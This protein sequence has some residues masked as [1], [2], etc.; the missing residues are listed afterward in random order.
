MQKT[1]N[2]DFNT[3]VDK[4][5][6]EVREG[7]A[8]KKMSL[9]DISRKMTAAYDEMRETLGKEVEAA[10]QEGLDTEAANCP[11]CGDG[12]KKTEIRAGKAH[13]YAARFF[14]ADKGRGLL[15]ELQKNIPTR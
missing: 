5:K 14:N 4:L 3:I 2:N 10:M 9:T 7:V 13:I 15:R 8:G 6:S 11:E 12:L 1:E